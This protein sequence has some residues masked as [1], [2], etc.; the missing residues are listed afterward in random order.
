MTVISKEPIKSVADA[1]RYH[2]KSFNV[3]AGKKA[4]NYY[5]NEKATAHW[6]GRGAE[7]LGIRGRAV[8]KKEFVAFLSGRM[9]HPDTGKIQNLAN[10]SKG[11]QRRPG[12]DFTIAPP[13]SVSI[14]GL[15]GKD[16]RVVAAHL[17]ANARAMKW[18]EKHASLIRVK[19]ENGRN[20]PELAGNLLYA[21]VLHETNREN[22]PQIHSHNVIVSAVYDEAR[23]TWRSL[24]NDLLHVLRARGDIIYKTELAA[25][26]KELG[27]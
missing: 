26:L 5:I 17:A 3:A 18:F 22:E 16:D 6:E 11:E 21:N 2:D 9:P 23:H 24:T 25:G 14:A 1:A 4:D 10:N 20:R 12:I 27:Y 19:D 15:V 7:I 8:T 13:K